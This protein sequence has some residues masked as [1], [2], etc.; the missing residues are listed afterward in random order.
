MH[1]YL[2]HFL[3]VQLRKGMEPVC[4]LAN[5]EELHLKAAER[6]GYRQAETRS[7]YAGSEWI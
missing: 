7:I 3:E 1:P 6:A 5:V 4:D 2:S